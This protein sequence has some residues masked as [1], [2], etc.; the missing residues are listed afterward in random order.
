MKG[1]FVLGLVKIKIPKFRK[2]QN[3]KENAIALQKYLAL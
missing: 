2:S 1:L 3:S